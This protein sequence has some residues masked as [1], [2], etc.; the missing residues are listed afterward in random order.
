MQRADSA[1]LVCHGCTMELGLGEEYLQCMVKDCGKLFHVLCTNKRLSLEEKDTWV[2]PECCNIFKKSRNCDTPVGTPI[3]IKNIAVRNKSEG[4]APQL[5]SSG[6]AA[7]LI[8]EVQLIREQMNML[9]ERLVDA[10]SA[11]AQYQA[12]LA[13]YTKKF[14][15][16]TERLMQ[17]EVPPTCHCVSSNSTDGAIPE[18]AKVVKKRRTRK[19]PLKSNEGLDKSDEGRGSDV[20]VETDIENPTRNGSWQSFNAATDGDES[21]SENWQVVRNRKARLSSARCTAGPEVT[22]LKAVEYRRYVHLWNMMSGVD[23]IR[24]YMQTL[25]PGN[26]FSVEEL[27]ARGEYKSYKIGVPQELFE[28]CLSP[29]VWPENARVKAWLFRRPQGSGTASARLVRQQ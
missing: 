16:V 26:G 9:S 15:V 24:A 22:S 11:V 3:T 1:E 2:C 14:E 23:D 13:D 10:I 28:K 25:C 12:E 6:E 21:A 29:E 4:P 7:N 19:Q 20:H 17:L 27:K 18:R 5:Q 8:L